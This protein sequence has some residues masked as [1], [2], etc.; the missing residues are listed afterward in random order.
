MSKIQLGQRGSGK[1]DAAS[2]KALAEQ[3]K[4]FQQEK[5]WMAMA[6]QYHAIQQQL[7][8]LPRENTN[9]A[10]F[11]LNWKA[12]NILLQ[13]TLGRRLYSTDVAIREIAAFNRGKQIYGA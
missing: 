13:Y 5:K 11:E 7:A 2:R 4:R 3:E 10:R 8:W 6:E 12:M 1:L 9:R